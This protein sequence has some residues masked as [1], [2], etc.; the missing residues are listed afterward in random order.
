ML[1]NSISHLICRCK[2]SKVA[3]NFVRLLSTADGFTIPS[4]DNIKENESNSIEIEKT[5]Q[6]LKEDLQVN[7]ERLSKYLASTGICSRREAEKWILDK[8]ISI[9]G[10]VCSSVSYIV[11]KNQ[12]KLDILVDGEPLHRNNLI[13]SPRLWIVYK[14]RGN[15]LIHVRLE[16]SL[17]NLLG[18]LTSDKDNIKN[19]PLMLERIN[20]LLK[21]SVNNKVI[22]NSA[23]NKST[24]SD[25]VNSNSTKL[26]PINRLDFNTEGL[27]LVT[28]NGNLA[29][30]M[31]EE[32]TLIREYRARIH[33]LL[34]EEKFF[35]LKKGIYLDG[36]SAYSLQIY[37]FK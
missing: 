18:E 4:T 5:T 7:G 23:T 33:G 10:V 3:L 8:R 2:Y 17:L 27:C 1:I 31:N 20:A 22:Q 29:R 11:P 19:R 13:K 16:F 21:D 30:T 36:K 6:N 35:A 32:P 37:F 9:K 12:G 25:A 26:V 14:A 24:Q 15:H 34:N 28:N